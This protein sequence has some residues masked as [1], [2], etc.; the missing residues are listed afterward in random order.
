MSPST[1]CIVRN[2]LW[3]IDGTLHD[4]DMT[5][6]KPESKGAWGEP[7]LGFRVAIVVGAPV[8]Q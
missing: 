7:V 5:T 2:V 6:H 4:P 3:I 1:I 8:D